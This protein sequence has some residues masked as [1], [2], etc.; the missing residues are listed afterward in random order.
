MTTE[1]TPGPWIVATVDHGDEKEVTA[2]HSQA[3]AYGSSRRR[4]DVV[5]PGGV[6]GRSLAECEANAHLI[7]AAPELLAACKLVIWKLNNN[8]DQPDYKGPAR[9]TREDATIRTMAAAI[10]AATGETS[11]ENGE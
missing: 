11:A 3:V 4:F 2:I 10:A 9:I 1:H 6:W 8:F 7:A 5:Q